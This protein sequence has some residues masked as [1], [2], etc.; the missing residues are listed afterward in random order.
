MTPLHFLSA[1]LIVF[2]TCAAQAQEAALARPDI[3]KRPDVVRGQAS[4]GS[5]CAACHGTNATGGMGPNLITSA[6]VRHDVNGDEIGKVIHEG[7]MDKGMPAFP[8]ITG[9]Q[10]TDIAAFLHARVTLASRASALSGSSIGASSLAGGSAPAGKEFFAARCASCH[11]ATGDLK[12]IAT[13]M[14]GAELMTTLL[15]PTAPKLRTGTV[16]PKR[17][18]AMKGTFLHRDAFTVTLRAAD[19][20]TKSWMTNEVAVAVD[21]PL[22]GHRD[23]LPTYTDKDLH[24]VFAYLE[25]LR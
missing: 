6:T 13:K 21:D 10:V 20:S 7:R 3:L 17:G 2:A 5:N 8:N 19:G 4:F 1:V 25:T 14:P 24:D 11:S 22:K 12:G 18:A 15:M 9:T 23:L 16:T